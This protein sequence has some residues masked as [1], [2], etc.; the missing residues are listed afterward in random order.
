M[1]NIMGLII[2]P[3]IT[4]SKYQAL[5][6]TFRED[7]AAM[8]KIKN[9]ALKIKKENNKKVFDLIKKNVASN[10]KTKLKKRPNFLL[11]GIFLFEYE[12]LVFYRT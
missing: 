2:L 6:K 11:D 12:V 1:P 9:K 5:F 4:P 7:G 3:R 10:A 8:D